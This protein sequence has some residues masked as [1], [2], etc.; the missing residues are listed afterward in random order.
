MDYPGNVLNALND[1][2]V[3]DLKMRLAIEFAK[4]ML[5]SGPD[6]SPE[7]VAGFAA[8]TADFLVKL[9]E[10]NAWIEAV[11]EGAEIPS[12]VKNQVKRNAAAQAIAQFHA[13]KVSAELAGPLM[14]MPGMPPG[15]NG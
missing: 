12:V 3:M 4:A 2:C 6:E 13:K 7:D 11:P 8:S 14:R 1:G 10:D 5:A 9:C 15:M